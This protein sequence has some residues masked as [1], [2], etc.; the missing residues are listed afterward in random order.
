MKQKKNSRTLPYIQDCKTG[1]MI[2]SDYNGNNETNYY[3]MKKYFFGSLVKSSSSHTR[4]AISI[5]SC[6][7]ATVLVIVCFLFFIVFHVTSIELPST[8]LQCPSHPNRNRRRILSI[9][10]QDLDQP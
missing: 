5:I 10:C 6:F 1:C 3:R 4:H 7:E 2:A 8:N 9:L